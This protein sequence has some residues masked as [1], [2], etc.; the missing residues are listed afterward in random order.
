[1]KFGRV[2][3]DEAVGAVL[4]HGLRLGAGTVFKKGR[5]LDAEDIAALR[6]A[7]HD[8]VVAARLEA[9]DVA[10]DAAAARLAAAVAGAGLRAGAAFTG[11]VN[12]FAEAAGLAE[13]DR[14]AL[15]RFNLVDESVTLATLPPF[16]VAEDGQMVA[17]LKVIPFAVPGAVVAACAAAAGATGLIRLAR[18][19]PHRAVLIQTRLP[20]TKERVLDKTVG[21]IG[22]R[23]ARRDSA[24]MRE[25]RCG[26]EE[27]A[28]AAALGRALEG[29]APDMVLIAGA[30]AITDR[31]DVVPAAILACGGT[32]TQFGMPVDPGNLM[33]IARIG[34]TPVLGLPG[35]ARSPKLNG[36][37]WVLDR[38]LAGLSVTARDVMRMGA[39]GLLKEIAGRP[40]PRAA[41][42]PRQQGA[43][44]PRIATLILA[45]G[46]SRRMG[47]VN[48]LLAEI[49][50]VPMVA[51]V[52][53][54]AL[55][56]R[57][58]RGKQAGPVLVVTG[59]DA[60][61]VRTALAGR[62]LDFVDNPDYREGISTSLVHGLAALPDDVDAVLVC[63]GD[64]PRVTTA[65][66]DRLIAAFDPVEGRAICVPVH[67]GKRGNPV[68]WARR[69]FNEMRTVA[70]DVGARHLIGEHADQVSEVAMDDDG[71]LVDVDSP[72]ALIALAP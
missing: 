41:A 39:G 31:R 1:M 50:H 28:L 56:S 57:A 72:D 20:G 59:H 12:L 54:A 14:A 18:F 4:A 3:L 25:A 44:G 58:A 55:A 51:R 23:L 71:V 66:L 61:R 47:R 48:K 33:L 5:V 15:D 60:G 45:A 9:D 10:E 52:A 69:F 17:T 35:C 26:H 43:S 63:L 30:S 13:I 27:N 8:S 36:F 67:D 16:A 32:I 37:D 68:L 49:D 22:D 2:A 24:L 29:E 34:E 70:G 7:G 53:D 40:L 21:V 46:R 64:M 62:P 19:R 11:R 6:T 42:H 65:H 38:L